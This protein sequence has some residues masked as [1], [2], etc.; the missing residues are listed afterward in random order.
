MINYELGALCH[1]LKWLN[2]RQIM[3]Y[4]FNTNII[5]FYQWV[6]FSIFKNPILVFNIFY[7]LYN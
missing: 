7:Q 6:A 2:F 3:Y 4:K 1:Y 5:L